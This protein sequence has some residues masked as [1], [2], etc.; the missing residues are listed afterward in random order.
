MELYSCSC[1]RYSEILPSV[2]DRIELLE[3]TFKEFESGFKAQWNILP[4]DYK[5]EL[6]DDITAFRIKISKIE[7]KYKLSK[8]RTGIERKNIIEFLSQSNDKTKVDIAKNMSDK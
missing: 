7:G 1:I 5:N 2:E 4:G 3:R 8:N 6:L